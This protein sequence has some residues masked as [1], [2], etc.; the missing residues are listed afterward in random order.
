MDLGVSTA[1]EGLRVNIERI[2]TFAGERANR[3]KNALLF[4]SQH[5]YNGSVSLEPLL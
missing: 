4:C 2:R 3:K 1:K 5:S